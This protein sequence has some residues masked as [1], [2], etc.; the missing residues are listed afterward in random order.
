MGIAAII[1]VFNNERTIADVVKKTREYVDTVLVVDDGST[2]GTA[3]ALRGIAE[4]G[5]CT[6]LTHPGNRGKGEALKTAISYLKRARE[7][8]KADAVVFLD[9]DGEHNPGEIPLF[10]NALKMADVVLG[11]RTSHRSKARRILN[12]WMGLWFRLLNPAVTDPSCGF[13]AMR[14]DV[15]KRLGL[16]SSDFCIDA[17]MIL[18]AIKARASITSISL[19]H[20][21]H[22]TSSVSSADF[23]RINNFF[24]RWVM[25]NVRHLAIRGGK[26]LVLLTGARA[27]N[28]LGT[29]LLMGA[30]GRDRAKRG[31]M[32]TQD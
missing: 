10:L 9:A 27:G 28:L 25:R 8:R 4:R 30:C 7:A 24:D 11:A 21:T 15:L 17:E 26:C 32:I 14:W 16:R 3:G 1:P 22:S 19:S 18:E 20:S 31:I 23:L 2:D 6:V 13:R 12:G 5:T 29:A